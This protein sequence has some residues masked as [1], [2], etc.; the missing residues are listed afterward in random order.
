MHCSLR[1]MFCDVGVKNLNVRP[2]PPT[3]CTL[4]VSKYS[5]VLFT[6]HLLPYTL[7]L[8]KCRVHQLLLCAETNLP[9]DV[10]DVTLAP[11]CLVLLG[12]KHSSLSCGLGN[13]ICCLLAASDGAD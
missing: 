8:D 1:N 11:F 10:Q 2:Y 4:E 7:P 3:R 6:V 12:Q 13:S 5:S 9:L